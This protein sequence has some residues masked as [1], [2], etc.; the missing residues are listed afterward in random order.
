[1]DDAEC[2][3]KDLLLDTAKLAAAAALSTVKYHESSFDLQK[4]SEDIDLPGLVRCEDVVAAV[5]EVVNKF[6]FSTE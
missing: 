3:I 2:R 1:L 4:V 6:H 5:E